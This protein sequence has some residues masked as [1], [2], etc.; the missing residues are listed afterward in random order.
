MPGAASFTG[1]N[2]YQDMIL[3]D[4]LMLATTNVGAIHDTFRQVPITG[5]GTRVDRVDDLDL[6]E[7]TD[8]RQAPNELELAFSARF[9]SYTTAH[10]DVGIDRDDW[11]KMRRSKSLLNSISGMRLMEAARAYHTK[12]AMKSFFAD[13]REGQNAQSTTTASFPT[14]T[15]QIAYNYSSG[16]F[17]QTAQT[18]TL[19][20]IDAV[21]QVLSNNGVTISTSNPLHIAVFEEIWQQFKANN[22]GTNDDVF[23][24][25]NFQYTDVKMSRLIGTSMQWQDIV[26]HNIPKKYWRSDINPYGLV[27]GQTTRFRL[28]TYVRDGMAF[29]MPSEVSP[30]DVQIFEPK[31]T[32]IESVK[33]RLIT[34]AGATRVDDDR[35]F[36]ILVTATAF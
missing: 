22:I 34:K 21:K 31:E 18:L 10:G 20:K 27:S 1:D 4:I 15:N 36:D 26:F 14:S 2:I 8:R 23:P 25:L 6:V 28:P 3:D 33:T 30:Y 12:I 19:D 16:A 5:Q 29:G 9:L 35:V 7:K 13:A 24:V 32:E 17:G 11:I